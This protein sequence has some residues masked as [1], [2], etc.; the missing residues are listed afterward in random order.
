MNAALKKY[1]EIQTAFFNQVEGKVMPDLPSSPNPRGER[2]VLTLNTCIEC[3]PEEGWAHQLG[4]ILK[5]H[6]IDLDQFVEITKHQAMGFYLDAG[7]LQCAHI[8]R[9]PKIREVLRI[10]AAMIPE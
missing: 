8:S 5:E 4:T 3:Y 6:G 1:L 10:I 9:C 7:E 2:Y